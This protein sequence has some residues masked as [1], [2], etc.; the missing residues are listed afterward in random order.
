MIR[1][2]KR[3]RGKEDVVEAGGQEQV[4]YDTSSDEMVMGNTYQTRKLWHN[5]CPYFQPFI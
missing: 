4:L 2:G 3:I 1:N 5:I